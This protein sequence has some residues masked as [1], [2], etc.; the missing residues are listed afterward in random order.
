MVPIHIA[1][2]TMALKIAKLILFHRAPI[3]GMKRQLNQPSV[4]VQYKSR[5]R[6]ETY[7]SNITP[8][9]TKTNI[10]MVPESVKET[11]TPNFLGS[12]F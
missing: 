6:E 4:I 9:G 5:G 2:T 12:P 11:P 7:T 8:T 10:A 1:A 3:V